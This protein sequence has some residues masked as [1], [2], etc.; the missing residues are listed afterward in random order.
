MLKVVELL[1]WA[2]VTSD[3][4]MAAPDDE[5]VIPEPPLGAADVSATVQ[6]EPVD[7]LIVSGLQE[8]PFKPGVCWIVTVLPLVAISMEA[9]IESAPRLLA[10]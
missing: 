2:T 3:G 1:P 4:T 9:A 8:N 10:S 7:G 6:V 5:I